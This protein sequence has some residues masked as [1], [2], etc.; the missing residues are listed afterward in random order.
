M[1]HAQEHMMFRGSPGLSAGQLSNLIAAIGGHFNANTQQTVT[2]YFLTVSPDDLDIAQ[3][4]G[5]IR[6]FS[7]SSF[8]GAI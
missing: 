6:S 4:A 1:A 5:T 3:I 8:T 2:Q 7:I